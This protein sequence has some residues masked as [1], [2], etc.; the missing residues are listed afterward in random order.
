MHDLAGL[1]RD[2][3]EA[4]NRSDWPKP[5]AAAGE[6]LRSEETGTNRHA[7][8]IAVAIA[9]L[10]AWKS[11]IPDDT[12]EVVGVAVDGEPT[13]L[14]L[15]WRGTQ[16]RPLATP[17]GPFAP[18]GR[19]FEVRAVLWPGWQDGRLV[20]EVAPHRRAEPVRATRGSARAA[21]TGAAM[22]AGG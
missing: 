17:A 10:Q 6:S 20:H 4:F 2:A 1:A 8:G 14:N 16:T 11:A 7:Y 5:V 19:P 15:L 13:V 12:G 9:L 18:S 21:V 22:V 3:I